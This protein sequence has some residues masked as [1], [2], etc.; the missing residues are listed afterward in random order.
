M[1]LTNETTTYYGVELTV[2]DITTY[3]KYKNSHYFYS[4]AN[5]SKFIDQMC[6]CEDVLD[7]D[8][9]DQTTGEVLFSANSEDGV[10]WDVRD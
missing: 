1:R 10:T 7:I 6:E 3:N 8:L 5:A 9:V 4:L 2:L